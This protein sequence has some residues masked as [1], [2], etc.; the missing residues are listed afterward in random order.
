MERNAPKCPYCGEEITRI[1]Y[2]RSGAKIFKD[3]RWEE[4][5]TTGDFDYRCQNCLE[6]LD[7][8]FLIEIGIFD[9]C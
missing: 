6:S 9:G 3:G 4:D 7:V 1:I 2:S 5:T 8:D